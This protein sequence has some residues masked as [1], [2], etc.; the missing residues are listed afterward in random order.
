[1]VTRR[2]KDCKFFVEEAMRK[3]GYT[4]ASEVQEKLGAKDCYVVYERF[5]NQI[6][7]TQSYRSMAYIKIVISIQ[8]N[9]DIPPEMDRIRKTVTKYVEESGAPNC[10]SFMFTDTD[11]DMFGYLVELHAIYHYETDWMN[12]F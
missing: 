4:V 10:T 7:T 1:M 11:V 8:S 6:E 5:G 9:N 12:E 3:L 2:L